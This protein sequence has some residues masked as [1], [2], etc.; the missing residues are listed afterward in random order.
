M[1]PGLPWVTASLWDLNPNK[2]CKPFIVANSCV[3][4]WVGYFNPAIVRV[5]S[6]SNTFLLQYNQSEK[7]N[8]DGTELFTCNCLLEVNDVRLYISI[9]GVLLYVDTER[10][11]LF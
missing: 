7:G 5:L 11:T 9:T 2:F 10:K 4:P 3:F 6:E 8:K 1:Y